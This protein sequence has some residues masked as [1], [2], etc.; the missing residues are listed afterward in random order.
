MRTSMSH[1]GAGSTRRALGWTAVASWAATVAFVLMLKARM[2]AFDRIVAD[3]L[4][5]RYRSLAFDMMPS[6]VPVSYLLLAVTLV[7]SLM[8]CLG[9]LP[10]PCRVLL[11]LAVTH[12]V[13]AVTFYVLF[14]ET[15]YGYLKALVL[16]LQYAGAAR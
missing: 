2:A 8:L 9:L 14:L 15:S 5:F 6:V 10:R 12:L 13:I 4:A 11:V 3:C 1:T 16:A 7:P